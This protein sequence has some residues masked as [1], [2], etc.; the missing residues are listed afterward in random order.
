MNL[1]CRPDLTVVLKVAPGLSQET[2]V[3]FVSG[4]LSGCQI[5]LFLCAKPAALDFGFSVHNQPGSLRLSSVGD[6]LLSLGA[7]CARCLG[8]PS[9]ES[10][11]VKSCF[12]YLSPS[13]SSH[14]TCR[15]HCSYFRGRL[16]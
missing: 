12:R 8:E 7:L 3:C 4:L 1:T 10:V 6:M 9:S 5:S 15:L 2:A 13:W 16:Q 14:P 11:P